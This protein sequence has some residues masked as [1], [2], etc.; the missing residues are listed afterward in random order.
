M[1]RK[2]KDARNTEAELQSRGEALAVFYIFPTWIKQFSLNTLSY[3]KQMQRALDKAHKEE[4]HLQANV[5]RFLE[6]A[7][8]FIS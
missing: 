1:A 8:N 3:Y 7:W 2:L 5:E 4:Q 6:I